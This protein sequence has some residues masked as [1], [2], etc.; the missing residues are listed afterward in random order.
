MPYTL[1]DPFQHVTI[2]GRIT[3]LLTE[4]ET[5]GPGIVVIEELMVA[6][7]RHERFGMPYLIQ[8][9][10]DPSFVIIHSQVFLYGQ[11]LT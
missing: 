7:T 9:R 4:R 8:C 10:E 1:K 2:V 6:P 3:E 5:S 11:S